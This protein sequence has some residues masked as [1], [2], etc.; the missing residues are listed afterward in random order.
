MKKLLLLLLVVLMAYPCSARPQSQR[1]FTYFSGI[2][3][4]DINSK[5]DAGKE[6]YEEGIDIYQFIPD[7]KNPATTTFTLTVDESD[8]EHFDLH[9]WADLN[10][11][12]EEGTYRKVRDLTY[13]N[14]TPGKRDVYV[15]KT[16]YIFDED[17]I[18]DVA[19]FEIKRAKEI[20]DIIRFYTFT[21]EQKLQ[22]D[23][24]SFQDRYGNIKTLTPID[25]F[26]Y[27]TGTFGDQWI[28]TINDL[29]LE[30]FNK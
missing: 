21:F 3:L 18:P 20:D 9:F 27:M 6:G 25:Y 29:I 2:K 22:G 14:T 26:N 8:I 4:T 13:R 30:L 10:E 7:Q 15:T 1:R 5:R 24:I 23:P 16:Y 28:H 11:R 12:D 19:I 17:N